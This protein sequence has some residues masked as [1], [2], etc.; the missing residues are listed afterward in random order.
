MKSATLK[1]FRGA[2]SLWA[3][4]L[5]ICS[6]LICQFPVGAEFNAQL[7][8][9]YLESQFDWAMFLEVQDAQHYLNYEGSSLRPLNKVCVNLRVFPPP[10]ERRPGKNPSKVY[11]DFW[12][13]NGALIGSRY[14]QKLPIEQD[15]LGA[16]VVGKTKGGANSLRAVANAIVRLT[17]DLHFKQIP[18]SLVLVP[19]EHYD[20]IAGY[21]ANYHFTTGR[22]PEEGKQ[23][24]IHLS[25]YPKGRDEYYYLY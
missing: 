1:Y 14:H 20:S 23:M 3:V 4:L 15:S 11:E 7:I 8:D 9:K 5:S 16:L 18:I 17:L 10:G 13:H 22:H 2:V 6:A 12:Y 21:L 24:S 19:S 25:S